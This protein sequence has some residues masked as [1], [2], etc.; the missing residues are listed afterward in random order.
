MPPADE[1]AS[2]VLGGCC[3][4]FGALS[5]TGCK[6]WR[7]LLGAGGGCNGCG[8]CAGCFGPT[9]STAAFLTRTTS[10]AGVKKESILRLLIAQ[11]ACAARTPAR[12]IASN[13]HGHDRG[14][15]EVRAC[16]VSV[17][18]P[19]MACHAV[20]NE[21]LERLPPCRAASIQN[22]SAWLTHATPH[23][24]CCRTAILIC[25]RARR[26]VLLVDVASAG[27][28]S[29]L[30]ATACPRRPRG[31]TAEVRMHATRQHERVRLIACSVSVRQVARSCV[32]AELPR[33]TRDEALVVAA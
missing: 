23:C 3:G 18:C 16:F 12:C 13:A 25:R 11:G 15:H 17:R 7:G 20:G 2:H 10:A 31:L 27:L 1:N 29:D 14:E 19:A 5:E 9:A 8:G 32:R 30:A 6:G 4:C 28:R 24:G 21:N 33:E 26:H 22:V